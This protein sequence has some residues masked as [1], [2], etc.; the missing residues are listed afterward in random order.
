MP[1]ADSLKSCIWCKEVSL[2]KYVVEA[3]IKGAP[4]ARYNK[5]YSNNFA[6]RLCI[7]KHN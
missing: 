7:V 4:E 3:D 5:L 2:H 6:K 1:H